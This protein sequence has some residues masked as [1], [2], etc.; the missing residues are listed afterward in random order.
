MSNLSSPTPS[1]GIA[2]H[3]IHARANSSSSA[4]APYSTTSSAELHQESASAWQR[5]AKQFF[6]IYNGVMAKK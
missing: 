5:Y 6:V 4:S 2:L 1:V 3:A